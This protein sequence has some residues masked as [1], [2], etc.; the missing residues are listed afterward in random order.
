MGQGA[1]TPAG[2]GIDALLHGHPVETMTSLVSR[3][4]LPWPVFKVKLNDPAFERW[5]KE[6]RLRRASPLSYFLVEAAHQALIGLDAIE[7]AQT[8]LV[9]AFS[10]GC[11]TYS[12]RFFED[13]VTQGHR[14]ASPVLFPETVYNSPVS[15][16]AAALHL[17]G[18]AYALVGDETAWIAAL[19][20]AWLWLEQ[21]RVKQV[22]VLGGEEFD[23]A[24]L[25]AYRNAR[26]LARP[27]RKLGFIPSEGAAGLLVRRAR[28]G[29]S[30]II[31]QM[32]DGFIY[33][34][35]TEAMAAGQRCLQHFDSHLPCHGSAQYNWLAGIERKLTQDHRPGPAIGN[36]AYLGEAA[37]ASAAWNTLRALA[38]LDQHH[39]R[40]LVPIWGSTHQIGA[41]QIENQKP[42]TGS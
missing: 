41:L 20:T 11:L 22:L 7:L 3:P 15:H 6:P 12:R 27:Q 13:I 37:T 21:E 2:V 35:K 28:P 29:D 32:D 36:L 26:W 38:S 23:S 33:R 16:V 5:Q 9:I 18:S 25:D 40:L 8:G 4:D 39:P 1:V 19:K 14:A 42:S 10:T 17:E 30:K 31:S 34:S 24:S